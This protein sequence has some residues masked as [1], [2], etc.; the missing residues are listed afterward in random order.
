MKKE[1]KK[2]IYCEVNSRVL[3]EFS[4]KCFNTGRKQNYVVEK[5]L[6]TFIKDSK[7]ITD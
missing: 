7:I 3:N 1:N 6:K 4:L 5:L 2:A